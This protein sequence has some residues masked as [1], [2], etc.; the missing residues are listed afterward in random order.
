[1]AH[2]QQLQQ[3]ETMKN[4]NPN[5]EQEQEQEDLEILKAVAQAWHG[6]SSSSKAT[7]TTSEFD[8]HR[9]HFKGKPTRFKIEAMKMKEKCGKSWD[10]GQSLWDSYEILSVSKKLERGLMMDNP[11][12]GLNDTQFSAFLS[13]L[14]N[15][16][17]KFYHSSS[18]KSL[19]SLC[20]INNLIQVLSVCDDVNSVLRK[21]KLFVVC[22]SYQL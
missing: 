12:S 1:M 8:A 7:K 3:K 19:H 22:F 5:Q 14:S 20:L 4:K 15:S 11:F 10:F 21:P 17:N 2:K 6:H 18:S 16:L 13:F 9:R